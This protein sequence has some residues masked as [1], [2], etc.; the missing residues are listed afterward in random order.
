MRTLRPRQADW[1]NITQLI[2]GELGAGN[3]GLFCSHVH[4]LSP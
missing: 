2:D 4:S 1:P 3:S